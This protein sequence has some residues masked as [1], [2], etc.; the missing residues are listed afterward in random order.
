MFS[1]LYKI[2]IGTYWLLIKIASFFNHKAKLWI[3][4]RKNIFVNLE[5]QNLK[6]SQNIWFHVSSLGEFEQA[7]TLI[8]TIKLK[9]TEFK[10]ILSFFSPSG[11]EIRKNYKFADFVCYLPLDTHKNAQRFIELINPQIAF[12]VKYDFWFHYLKTLKNKNIPTYLVSAIFRENQIFFKKL[13]KSYSK[14][15][16][17]FTHFFVQNNKSADLSEKLGLKNYTIT[18]D[19]RFDRVIQIAENPVDLPIIK[20]FVNNQKC[21]VAG[22]TWQA[23]EIILAKYHEKFPDKKI[24]IVPHEIDNEHIIKTLQLFKTKVILYSE[25]K[26]IQLSDY[27]VMIINTIGILSSVYKYA[28]LAYIGGG[29]GAGIHNILE[30]AVYGIPV[31]FGPKYKK[32]K[33]AIDLIDQNA[34]FSIKDYYQFEQIIGK[35]CNSPKTYQLAQQQAKNYV[36]SNKGASQKVYNFVFE[37]NT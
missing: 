1:I 5:K 32:F 12:F 14:V 13:G 26:N 33:E 29:F 22:S 18:G 9:K 3:E 25:V 36:F 20:E 34:A 4:G 17:Y 24:I 15:L 16:N 37:K 7:R 6:N 11:Y 23:D 28:N 19:T 27:N 21:I 2:S 30:A 35:L 8:E 31:I 10:I